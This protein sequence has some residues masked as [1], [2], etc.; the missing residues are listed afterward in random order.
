MDN[1]MTPDTETQLAEAFS[2][3]RQGGPLLVDFAGVTVSLDDYEGI[4]IV[5]R[6]A[7]EY[8]AWLEQHQGAFLTWVA[9][10]ERY[11]SRKRFATTHI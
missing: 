6:E 2:E 11:Y 10:G 3:Y 5:E 1:T 7:D 9:E 8:E 4:T